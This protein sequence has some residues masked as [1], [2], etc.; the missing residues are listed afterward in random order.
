M[1]RS[2]VV[3]IAPGSWRRYDA[4]EWRDALVL[5]ERGPV[6]LQDRD[7]GRRAFARGAVLW[8]AGLPLAALHNPGRRPVVLIA[9]TRR[10][11]ARTAARALPFPSAPP[12]GARPSGPGRRREARAYLRG[13]R[14]NTLVPWPTT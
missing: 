14:R 11:R 12:P 6:E 3:I 1:F 13:R 4:T 10:P 5:V 2:R 7:G 8:L 9:I